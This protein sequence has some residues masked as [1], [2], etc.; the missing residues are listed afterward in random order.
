MMKLRR[1]TS[2]YVF[3]LLWI[4]FVVF[5]SFE[6]NVISS[7]IIW[8][9]ISVISLF[10]LINMVLNRSY[11]EVREDYL[12]VNKDFF[13]QKKIYL[14]RIEKIVVESSLFRF[15]RISIKNGTEIKF[16]AQYL[17]FNEFKDFI[18]RFNIVVEYR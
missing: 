4:A 6:S 9:G 15:S 11:F 1:P 5:R 17:D 7:K 8:I 2:V 3:Q 12:L 10:S 13:Q 16:N 14:S 18:A